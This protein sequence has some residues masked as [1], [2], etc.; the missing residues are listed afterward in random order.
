MAPS[1]SCVIS[2]PS[3]MEIL[4]PAAVVDA[5]SSFCLYTNLAKWAAKRK[6]P[7]VSWRDRAGRVAA[8]S[9]LG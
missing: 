7:A 9:S 2:K 4:L 5:I 1:L 3:P 6:P 8:R